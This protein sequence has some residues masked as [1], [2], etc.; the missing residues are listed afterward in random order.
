M[1]KLFL[2]SLFFL[3]VQACSGGETYS[4]ASIEESALFQFSMPFAP[5]VWVV[6]DQQATEALVDVRQ[7]KLNG[8][9]DAKHQL[10]FY[11]YSDTSGDI[12]LSLT[13][14]FPQKG[15]LSISLA[16]QKRKVNFADSKNGKLTLGTFTL[17]EPG[18]HQLILSKSLLDE[19]NVNI[20][21]VDV[22]SNDVARFNFITEKEVYFARRGPSAHLKYQLPNNEQDWQWFYSELE[23][24][25][26]FDPVGSYFMANGFAQ[27]YFGMQVNSQSERRVLFSVWSPF[28]T[29]DPKNVPPEQQI[30]LI[31]KGDNV[32]TGKF[33]NEGVGGQS[34]KKFNWQA[35]TKYKFLLKVS[36]SGD[37]RSEF[38]AYFYAP[39]IQQWQLI[40]S[41][42]R[43]KT[44][45]YLQRPHA[46]IENFITS[47]GDK[48]RKANYS[49][50][51]VAD[52]NGN[53]T[54][55]NQANVTY[56]NTARNKYRFDYQGGSEN[57][58]VYLQNGGFFN[59]PT[60]YNKLLT[61]KTT[62]SAPQINFD[63]LP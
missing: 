53:W 32:H 45:T 3:G 19:S 8:W 17:T 37:N 31:R 60:S 40:A 26:G 39:E 54:Q 27:G 21:N 11:F 30:K 46:F 50:Q 9:Q 29:Q 63:L 43:P 48:I 33:G 18:Y 28:K 4:Q 7:A 24:P 6:D 51:W 5:N 58:S 41:F 62:N 57:S 1:K 14:T 56:D 61:I 34:Y 59:D 10:A 13:G 16:K 12:N 15:E 36:P 25:K 52:T 22:A 42:Q 49:N 23:V 35:G 44:S 38:T 20:K 55:I 2:Y 47:Q